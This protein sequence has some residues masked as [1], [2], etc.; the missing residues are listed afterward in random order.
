MTDI[1][2]LLVRLITKLTGW[3]LHMQLTQGVKGLR[4]FPFLQMQVFK[5]ENFRVLLYTQHA[6][7]VCRVIIH[8]KFAKDA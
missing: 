1:T 2:S 7:E 8:F 4:D 6:Y 5:E 3:P